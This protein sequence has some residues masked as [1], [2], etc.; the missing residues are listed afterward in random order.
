MFAPIG[1]LGLAVWILCAMLLWF[2]WWKRRR[3][4]RR[5]LAQWDLDERLRAR[6]DADRAGEAVLVTAPP[7][8]AWTGVDPLSVDPDDDDEPSGPRWM[9]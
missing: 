5:R 7:Y 6:A 9:N 3:S 8:V 2:A 4:N 1:M